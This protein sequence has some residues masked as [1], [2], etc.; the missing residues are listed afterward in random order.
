MIGRRIGLSGN[1][2]DMVV[3]RQTDVQQRKFGS[4]WGQA[5]VILK[6]R[7]F[8]IQIERITLPFLAVV[9]SNLHV[10][11]YSSSINSSFFVGKTGHKPIIHKT[12]T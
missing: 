5:A 9:V 10:G 12:Y 4:T 11:S 6:K 1:I 2:Q 7:I 8:E 3:V